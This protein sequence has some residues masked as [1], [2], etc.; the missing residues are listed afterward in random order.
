MAQLDETLGN[1]QTGHL[2][3]HDK[4]HKKANYVFDVTDYGAVGDGATDDTAAIQ[5]A[6]D[7]AEA[8]ANV[9]VVLFPPKDYALSSGLTCDASDV[10]F[11]GYGARLLPDSAFIALDITSAS[12]V[13]TTLAA[14]TRP[15]QEKL[16]LTSAASISV[17]DLLQVRSDTLWHYDNRGTAVK[18]ELQR[19][20]RIDGSDVYVE[21]HVH[22]AYDV[23]GETVTVTAYTPLNNMAIRGL[24]VLY[25]ANTLASGIGL[26]WTV[27]AVIED[28][29]V[30][31]AATLGIALAS[32][33]ET[34]INR[35][36]IRSA[37]RVS[38]GYG[39]STSD[40]FGTL[41]TD[42]R[43]FN[44][45]R[46]V[47]FS[48]TSPSRNDRVTGCFVSGSGLASDGTNNQ[49]QAS[50][51]GTHGPA[52]QTVFDNNTII[53]C[54]NGIYVRGQ[55]TT[56]RDNTF[57]G[58]V[59]NVILM[60]YGLDLL[61]KD[62]VANAQV[63]PNTTATFSPSIHN[64]KPK[65][66]LNIQSTVDADTQLHVEGNLCYDLRETFCRF[67]SA[68]ASQATIVNNVAHLHAP[69]AGTATSFLKANTATTLSSSVVAGNHIVDVVGTFTNLSGVTLDS[70]VALVRPPTTVPD[71]AGARDSGEGALADLLTELE[72]LGLITDSSTAS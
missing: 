59:D 30:E 54:F 37:N 72:T 16:E 31:N 4:L 19:V 42:C 64:W 63:T 57:S 52:D 60:S 70:T 48:G 5:A 34:T 45:R 21:A 17:G 1:G 46:G 23:P 13:S 26:D 10:Q 69:S 14:D 68:T 27:R 11:L 67:D 36:T 65:R 29:T 66:F 18:G 41:V 38:L 32:C 12:I 39:I 55:S 47:D 56:I 43:F 50:G 33:Y 62:N 7:A 49:L 25:A 51:M 71:V 3:D 58:T 35:C 24:T 28:V 2:S 44:C 61:V 20:T 9:G 15:N 6:I 8:Y 53:N 22:D 40:T